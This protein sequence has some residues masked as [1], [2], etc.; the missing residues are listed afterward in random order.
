MVSYFK[1]QWF[2]LFAAIICLVVSIYYVFQPTAETIT[3][4]TLDAMVGDMFCAIAYFSN[5]MVLI[6]MSFI[7]YFRERIKLLEQKAEKYDALVG[8]VDALSRLLET[9]CKYS[10]QLNKR[11]DRLVYS[12][13]NEI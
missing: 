8:K 2:K 7:D 1:T 6:S 11:I 9:E 5:F 10:S 13:G 4:E 12:G 3:V